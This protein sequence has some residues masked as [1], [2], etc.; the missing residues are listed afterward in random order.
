MNKAFSDAEEEDDDDDAEGAG[1]AA[2]TAAVAE[3]VSSIK[4]I[5]R[6]DKYF[7]VCPCDCPAACTPR[8]LPLLS[9]VD[10]STFA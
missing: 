7:F 5:S 9:I 10:A 3:S 1:L 2:A 6:S 8:R 4:L